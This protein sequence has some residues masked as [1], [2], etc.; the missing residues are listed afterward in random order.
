MDETYISMILIAFESA[1]LLISPICGSFLEKIGRKNS[2]IIG[3]CVMA[4]A[5]LGLGLA[6]FITDDMTF[7][8]VSIIC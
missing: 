3:S 1:A 7:Y 5:T 2:M 6:S 8:V 4:V